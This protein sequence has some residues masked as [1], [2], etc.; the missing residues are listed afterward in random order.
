[1]GTD[2]SPLRPAGWYAD[3]WVRGQRR[4]WTGER[5]SADV[6][7][8]G[9]QQHP[10]AAFVALYGVPPTAPADPAP[11]P[12]S[13]RLEP[14]APV[15][16][17]APSNAPVAVAEGPASEAWQRPVL[18]AAIVA[19]LVLVA[20]VGLWLRSDDPRTQARPAASP[21]ASPAPT[22]PATPTPEPSDSPSGS[23]RQQGT[24]E[25]ALDALVLHQR[26][27]PDK[28]TVAPIP[29][30]R[31]ATDQP[32]LDL[33]SA[34]YP[35]EQD[36]IGRLQVS[37]KDS[38]QGTTLS[39]E[40]VQYVSTEATAQAFDEVAKVA[41]QC[42]DE[43]SLDSGS[44]SPIQTTVTAGAD[45]DWGSTPGVTRLAYT[46]ADTD[47]LGGEESQQVVV[48]L[49]RG[50]LLMGLYFPRPQGR[51]MPVEGKTTI[52]EIVEIFEKRLLDTPPGDPSKGLPDESDPSPSATQGGPGVGA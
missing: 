50:P 49:R 44:V 6:F 9:L 52:P 40:A 48:Y 18:I 34:T 16:R 13:F 2:E 37:A 5:W 42:Q 15:M 21:S 1:M 33:C 28:Y 30:G 32:T 51:Q 7:A 12:P 43:V 3:P 38:S 27:V 10:D 46:V 29:G 47:L 23:P 31:S 25:S 11:P 26:D 4:Y 41:A 8:D 17:L 24:V 19:A 20:G 36:R 22:P 14:A 35:S 39:T 45:R